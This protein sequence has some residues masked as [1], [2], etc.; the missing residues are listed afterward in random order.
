MAKHQEG[1]SINSQP[2]GFDARS[3]KK[4]HIFL[5]DFR[6]EELGTS[7]R[8]AQGLK[9]SLFSKDVQNSDSMDSLSCGS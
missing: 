1:I 2:Q 7:E 9:A 4:N 8:E 6:A 5:F 3:V